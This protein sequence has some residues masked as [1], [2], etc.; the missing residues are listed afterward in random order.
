MQILKDNTTGITFSPFAI[1][2]VWNLQVAVLHYFSLE[3]PDTALPEQDLWNE[4]TKE[5]GNAVLDEGFPKPR[6]EVLIAGSWHSPSRQPEQGGYASFK[7]G[8]LS[9]RLAVFGPRYWQDLPLAAISDPRAVT[10]VPLTWE[11][12]LGGPGFADNPAGIGTEA[13]PAPWGG[14]CRPLPLAED[15]AALVTSPSSRP[16]PAS[17]LPNTADRPAR[18]ALAGT[19]D[20]HWLNTAWPGF[21]DDINPEFFM[22][23]DPAQR[24]P[25]GY[26]EGAAWEQGFFAGGEEF[27]LENMH[28]SVARLAGRLPRK[29]VRVFATRSLAKAGTGCPPSEEELRKQEAEASRFEEAQTHLETVWFFPGIKRG[30][31][32]FRCVLPCAD[33]E[34]SDIISLMPVVED[35]DAPLT[36][37]AYWLEEKKKRTPQPEKP[38]ITIPPEALAALESASAAVRTLEEDLNFSADKALGKAPCIQPDHQAMLSHARAMVSQNLESLEK[39][40]ERLADLKKEYGAACKVHPND[41]DG[42]KASLK[43][44][45]GRLDQTEAS[46]KEAEAL[47]AEGDRALAAGIQRTEGLIE[48]IQPSEADKGLNEGKAKLHELDSLLSGRTWSSQ[49]LS[50]LSRFHL[51]SSSDPA[52]EALCARLEQCGLR[53]S[54]IH[55]ALL[56]YLPEAIA[57]SPEDLCLGRDE[58]QEAAS[59]GNGKILLPPGLVV[60]FFTKDECTALHIRPLQEDATDFFAPYDSDAGFVVPGSKDGCQ[61]LGAIRPKPVLVAEDPLTAWLMYAAAGDLFAILLVTGKDAAISDDAGRALD[62]APLVFW[63][64]PPLGKEASEDGLAPESPAFSA[65]QRLMREEELCKKWPSLAMCHKEK[66]LFP[67]AWPEKWSTPNLAKARSQGLDIRAWLKGE[68][69]KRGIQA[70]GTA[71]GSASIETDADGRQ[72]IALKVPAIDIKGIRERLSKRISGYR[73]AG[74]E[75]AESEFKKAVDEFNVL[76][77]QN[78]LKPLELPNPTLDELLHT[79][80]P[81][82]PDAATLKRFEELADMVGK[83]KGQ[84]EKAKILELRDKYLDDMKKLGALDTRARAALLAQQKEMAGVLQGVAVPGAPAQGSMDL[85]EWAREIPGAEQSLSGSAALP[86]SAAELKGGIKG[87]TIKDVDLSGIDLRGMSL[88]NCFLENVNFSNALLDE[89]RWEKVMAKGCNFTGASLAQAKFVQCSL[90]ECL[91]VKTKLQN[92][93]AELCQWQKGSLQDPDMKGAQVRLATFDGVKLRGSIEQA[94]FE[95]SSFDKCPAEELTLLECTL[96]KVSFINVLISRMRAEGGAWKE[97]GFTT[98]KGTGLAVQRLACE[99][100][101]FLMHCDIADAV[102]KQCRLPGLCLRESRLPALVMKGCSFDDAMADYCDLP[103]AVLAGCSGTKA[104]FLH[105]DLEGSDL[106]YLRLPQGSLRKSRLV[107][108]NLHCADLYGADMYKAVLGE[109]DLSGANLAGTLLEGKEKEMQN[110][111]LT[112]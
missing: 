94:S 105:C 66:K 68:L 7:A 3:R 50:L 57:L 19:Y 27:L 25:K 18:L 29:R 75:Q 9:R 76:R 74:M 36:D 80:Y 89:S 78:G 15:P 5:L 59:K 45:L 48:A 104:R 71:E 62:E 106:R 90:E 54:D 102:F 4:C 10:S 34:Y 55:H 56:A 22:T 97:T 69:E 67:I 65:A 77:R 6:G 1:G 16:R 64:V 28:P 72:D 100:M 112:R 39:G 70:A 20:T 107:Q 58:A 31:A 99:N 96:K 23:A 51:L 46:L 109:T 87:R 38:K 43:G 33:D 52:A 79:P 110:L 53:K 93:R 21:P 44:M 83:M 40:I 2:G 103:R 13:I 14:M 73:P 101:R 41:F 88:E 35:R 108:A 91:F 24:L 26:N 82:E 42:L 63:P 85:P 32:I 47:L 95:L 60:P 84:E 98:C 92:A 86:P 12:A 11:S 8:P 49:A 111:E 37:I 81:P 30:C 17:F 61:I